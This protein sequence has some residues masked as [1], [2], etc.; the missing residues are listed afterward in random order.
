VFEGIERFTKLLREAAMFRQQLPVGIMVLCLA[1]A[2][3]Q[4][5]ADPVS[6]VRGHNGPI[7]G[8]AFTADGARV[9][10]FALAY[11]GTLKISDT[12]DGKDVAAKQ[13]GLRDR[14]IGIRAGALSPDGKVLVLAGKYEDFFY[15]FRYDLGEGIGEA[16]DRSKHVPETCRQM[17]LAA[18][19][20]TVV[21]LSNDM[22]TLHD[23]ESFEQLK[24][25]NGNFTAAAYSPDNKT[26]AT[27]EAGGEIKVWKTSN[28]KVR[29][30]LSVADAKGADGIAQAHSLAFDSTS[31]SVAAGLPNGQTQLWS[32]EDGKLRGVLKGHEGAVRCIA[33]SADGKWIATGGDDHSIKLWDA[34]TLKERATIEAHLDPVTC[35]AFSPDGKYL[36]SGSSDK[37]VKVWDVA[38]ALAGK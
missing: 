34:A 14:S 7:G 19:H 3:G 6:T 25:I 37:L 4:A 17:V 9:V 16:K 32:T 13:A 23:M 36:A 1:L 30:T 31:Q 18:D 15:L 8:V 2:P 38:A 10:S 5:S 29:L 33:F 21:A 26:M 27:A 20:K 24:S 12:K 11:G 28:L 35:L 22:L